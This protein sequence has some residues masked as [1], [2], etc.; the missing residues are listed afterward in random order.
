MT[1][2]S[3]SG[4][5]LW[6]VSNEAEEK[7]LIEK[8]M[9]ILR[10]AVPSCS[11]RFPPHVTLLPG[12]EAR[13]TGDSLQLV[14]SRILEAIERWKKSAGYVTGRAIECSFSR[15]MTNGIYFQVCLHIKSTGSESC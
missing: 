5:S 13:D 11:A 9:E 7:K 1:L 3:F 12:I 2:F 8:Q 4:L 14:W 10:G 15:L 6:L